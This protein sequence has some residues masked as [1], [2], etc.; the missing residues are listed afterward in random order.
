MTI[1]IQK[2]PEVSTDT[3]LAVMTSLMDKS[4]FNQMNL[5]KAV[6][7]MMDV[8]QGYADKA[9]EDGKARAK[10]MMV[11]SILAGCLGVTIGIGYGGDFISSILGD[12][13]DVMKVQN[14]N[15]TLQS[16]IT[17]FLGGVKALS[18]TEQCGITKDQANA[19]LSGKIADALGSSQAAAAKTM[20]GYANMGK[21]L[22]SIWG[23][24][25]RFNYGRG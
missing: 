24:I 3:M 16:P 2:T 12:A 25:N 10:L 5:M 19:D 6:H 4:C 13:G 7:E 11:S 22:I 20:Q 21:S 23:Y 1:Q 8:D 18:S 17:G 15:A 14:L 9:V